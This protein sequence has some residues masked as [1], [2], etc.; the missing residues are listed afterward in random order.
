MAKQVLLNCRYFVGPADLTGHSN[1]VEL[2][3][4]MEE[5]ETTNYGSGGAKELL[6]GIESVEITGEGQWDAGD[7]G[8]IDDE[9][10]A[11]RRVIEA[12]TVC[13]ETAAVGA[14]AY[15]TQAVRLDSKL[16]GTVGDVAPWTLTAKGSWPL[17]RGMVLQAP[18]SAITA[19]AFGTG[20]QL[21]AVSATQRLYATLHL[22]SVAGTL[23]PDLTVTIQSDS[24]D[25]FGSPTTVL[26]FSTIAA[27]GDQIVRTSIGA[28]TDTWYRAVFDVDDH[29]GVGESFLALIALAIA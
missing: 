25:T 3:D 8:K 10:W 14:L 5:K 18:G 20:V 12:H 13:P 28:I 7:P 17:A 27:V 6:A 23:S 22:L 15:L 11:A 2:T 24:A 9:L 21:G 4:S 29:G 26:S 1:K 19:D 16:F